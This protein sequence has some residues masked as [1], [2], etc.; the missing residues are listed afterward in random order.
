MILLINYGIGNIRSVAN[1]LESLGARTKISE[2]PE[3]LRDADRIVL[4]GVGAFAEAMRRL[5]AVGFPDALR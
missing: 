4:P 3:D 1:A 2:R 5:E